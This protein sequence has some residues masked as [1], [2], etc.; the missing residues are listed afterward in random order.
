VGGVGWF[1]EWSRFG[2]GV[3]GLVG[4]EK[5][6][7]A[8]EGV[9]RL[10]VDEET[11][12]RDLREGGVEGADDRLHSES[13]DLDAGG[14]VIYKAT[15]EVD[16]GELA[17]LF[18][19]GQL[20]IGEEEDIVNGG[21]ALERMRGVGGGVGGQE[22]FDQGPSPE[23]WG[24]REGDGFGSGG[25][26]GVSVIGDVEGDVLR[27]GGDGR[28]DGGCVGGC[29]K[30]SVGLFTAVEKEDGHEEAAGSEAPEENALVA[31]D[32]FA[33]PAAAWLVR[34]ERSASAI[35][36]AIFCW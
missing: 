29:G 20:R 15:A 26:G 3:C 25:D 6:S 16:D 13:F 34:Q 31:G 14:V 19:R 7:V 23:G 33:A 5:V 4:A 11:D 10:A 1:D 24:L 18:A 35:A 8:G 2:S 36:L 22:V 32:H 27:A 30:A 12:C 21:T 17:G 28:G 9:V